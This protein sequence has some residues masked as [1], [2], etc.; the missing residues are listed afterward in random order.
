MSQNIPWLLL[1]TLA[2]FS[3]DSIGQEAAL[4]P[5]NMDTPALVEADAY[6]LNNPIPMTKESV[7]KGAILF[8]RFGCSDCHIVEGVGSR[9]SKDKYLIDAISSQKD[10]VVFAS[11]RDGAGVTMRPYKGIIRTEREIW[12][13]VNFIKNLVDRKVK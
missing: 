4:G 10:G 6:S 13:I 8:E 3:S 11:I 9:N 7:S 12:N 5:L 2:A 1:A